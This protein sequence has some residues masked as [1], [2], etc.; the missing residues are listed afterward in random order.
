[1]D[2]RSSRIASSTFICHLHFRILGTDRK[3]DLQ[4]VVLLNRLAQKARVVAVIAD[5]LQNTNGSDFPELRTV[6]RGR[7]AANQFPNLNW[8][9]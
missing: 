5:L 7:K 9:S 1:M 2:Y 8:E 3:N 4:R 6:T